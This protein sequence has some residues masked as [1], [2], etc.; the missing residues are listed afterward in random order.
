M[1]DSLQKKSKNGMRKFPHTVLQTEDKVTEKWL[2][3]Q[4]ETILR[5]SE[6][7]NKMVKVEKGI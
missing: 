6:R 1:Q 7:G 3:L 4:S 2:C 5:W